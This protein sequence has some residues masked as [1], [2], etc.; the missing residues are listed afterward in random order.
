MKKSINCLRAREQDKFEREG[1]KPKSR[2]TT[3]FMWRWKRFPQNP[4]MRAFSTPSHVVNKIRL[5]V[6]GNTIIPVLE[7]IWMIREGRALYK[8]LAEYLKNENSE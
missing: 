4:M 3:E 8:A 1:M 5:Q 6:N 7:L 2:F